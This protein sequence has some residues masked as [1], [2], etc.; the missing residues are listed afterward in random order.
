MKS[1]IAQIENGQ[2]VQIIVATTDWAQK[3]LDGEWAHSLT[4]IGVG[5]LYDKQN[6]LRPPQPYPSWT[7]NGE[8]WNPPVPYPSDGNSYAWDEDAQAWIIEEQI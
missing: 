7:W 6:G 8:R 5:W 1:Y 4:K 3:H 2:V